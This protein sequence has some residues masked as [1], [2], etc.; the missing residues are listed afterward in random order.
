MSRLLFDQNLSPHL[1]QRLGELFPGSI[2]VQTI[3]LA[4]ASDRTVWDYAR[5]N[6]YIVV[7]KDADLSELGT[8][9]GFSPKV[10]WIRRGNCATHEIEQL[11]QN[12]QAAI[13]LLAQDPESGVLTLF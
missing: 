5:A 10:I 9:L 6:N 2:H 3:G 4:T 13:E 1:V 8:L 12:N 7:T 11:L